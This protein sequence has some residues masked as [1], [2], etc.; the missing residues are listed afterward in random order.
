MVQAV[1]FDMAGTTVN[2]QNLVYKT[3]QKV[4]AKNN[5]PVSLD[6]VLELGAGKEKLTA[7]KD[8]LQHQGA[9]PSLASDIFGE[10][11][12]MLK[13]AYETES[14]LPASGAERL[15]ETLQTNGIK[16]ALN[17]GYGAETVQQLLH[18]LKWE[19][20]PHINCFIN[21]S[22]VQRGR[23]FPDM[24]LLAMEKMAITDSKSVIKI[25]DSG[26]DIEEG[27]QADCLY[28]IG[29]TTGAQT[30]SQLEKSNPDFVIHH[31]LDL[32]SILGIE[33]VQNKEAI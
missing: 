31:L 8:I 16:V 21:A 13:I 7:I 23:P 20:H 33:Q 15:F 28:S 14:V 22:D 30:Q 1:V 11:K 12:S 27:Q 10:F 29:I 32:L 9:D 19:E 17:T 3:L 4:I 26:V 25:G 18:R 6:L 24:I 5:I 2:E